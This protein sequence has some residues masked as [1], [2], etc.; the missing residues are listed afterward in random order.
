MLGSLV[1]PLEGLGVDLCMLHAATGLP[2]PGC[3]MTRGIAAITQGEFTVAAALNPFAFL[4][5]PTFLGLS[6]LAAS[7]SWW[8]QRVEAWMSGRAAFIG[9]AY[10]ICFTAF[11]VFGLARFVLFLATGQRFP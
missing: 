1:M 5:W 4:A 7:P 11:L 3:G 8:S 6:V 9:R 10:R 2:C